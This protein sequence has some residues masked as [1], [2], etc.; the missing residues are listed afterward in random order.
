MEH[1]SGGSLKI[2]NKCRLPLTAVK[3]V[4]MIITEKAVFNVTEK[5]LELIE[6]NPSSSLED[7]KATTEADFIVAEGLI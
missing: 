5:G 6:I 4:D 1:T 3:V 2:L 7:I